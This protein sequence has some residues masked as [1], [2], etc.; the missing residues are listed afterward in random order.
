MIMSLAVS[1]IV[2]TPGV[3]SRTKPYFSGDAIIYNNQVIVGTTNM[4]V[5]ELFKQNGGRL[6]RV[7]KIESV[8]AQNLK[9]NDFY[10]LDFSQESGRLFVYAV[11]GRNLFKYDVSNVYEP[12]LIN[13]IKDNSFDYFLGVKKVG[14]RLYTIGTNGVKLWNKDFQ[15]VDSYKVYTRHPNNLVFDDEGRFIYNTTDKG[16]EIFDTRE[17]KV[18]VNTPLNVKENHDRKVFYEVTDGKIYLIDDSA[19]KELNYGGNV[20]KEVDHGSSLGYYIDGKAGQ[21][22][23]Y[24]SSGDKVVKFNKE[25]LKS[26]ISAKTKSMGSFGSWAVGLR[27]I[28]NSTNESVVVFNTS[29]ILVLDKNLNLTSSYKAIEEDLKPF[30]S[31]ALG[32]DKTTAA[33]NSKVSVRGQGFGFN[34]NLEIDFAG[35]KTNV[36]TDENGRFTKII[37]VPNISSKR[38]DIKVTGKT[39]KLSYSISFQIQ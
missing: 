33:A 19:L 16:L 12:I 28:G 8:N 6:D 15:V 36:M 4:G 25:N 17:R 10:N 22:H 23:L 27:A 26:I 13:K 30:E 1:F 2:F 38:T 37:N 11:D 29:G 20:I 24:Y 3:K 21:S 35:E 14:S 34:E 31:L 39:S 7:A 32:L 18:V 5:L 9:K